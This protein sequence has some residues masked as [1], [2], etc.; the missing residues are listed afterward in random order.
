MADATAWIEFMKDD[1]AKS[2][3]SALDKLKT[4]VAAMK[5]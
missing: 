3:V 4:E 1:G 2:I 5:L